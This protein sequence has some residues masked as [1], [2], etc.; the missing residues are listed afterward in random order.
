MTN[1]QKPSALQSFA[2]KRKESLIVSVQNST[3]PGIILQWVFTNKF[4]IALMLIIMVLSAKVYFLDI[5]LLEQRAVQ[6]EEEKNELLEKSKELKLKIA[7]LQED[8]ERADKVNE[9]VKN[10][11]ESL[12]AR[13]KKRK[14]L[15]QINSLKLK[16]GL[17]K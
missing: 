4:V 17:F 5:A 16:R 3:V 11:A 10:Q 12:S 2:E 9:K 13:Q 14:I 8:S 6:L 1:E 15:Q 7:E